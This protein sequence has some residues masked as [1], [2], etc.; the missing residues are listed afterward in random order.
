MARK[1]AAEGR[2]L[3]LCARRSEQLEAIAEELRAINPGIRVITRTLDVTD[4][5]DVFDA[6]DEF[7]AA[8]GS[9]D[10]VIVNAG[11]AK[12]RPHGT[13]SLYAHPPT[14]TSNR[15]APLRHG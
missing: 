4:G 12:G 1:F 7:R 10:R 11:L 8:L 5:D 15:R 3:A 9:L 2:N 6:F 13:R 14:L